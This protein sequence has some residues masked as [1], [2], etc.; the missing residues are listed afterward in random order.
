MIRMNGSS[1][2]PNQAQISTVYQPSTD[3]DASN[4]VK[5]LKRADSVLNTYLL[6]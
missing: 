6:F 4:F 2:V 3:L 5:K 1:F